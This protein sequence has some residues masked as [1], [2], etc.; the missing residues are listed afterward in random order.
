MKTYLDNL[1]EILLTALAGTVLRV[2]ALYPVLR[3]LL[4]GSC[5]LSL[6]LFAFAGLLLY[7]FGVLPLRSFGYMRLRTFSGGS[8]A[9]GRVGYGQCLSGGLSRLARGIPWCVPLFLL[10]GFW[11]YGFTVMYFQDW[12]MHVLKPLGALV[13]GLADAGTGVLLVLILLSAF[14]AALGWWLDMES[15]FRDLTVRDTRDK[16]RRRRAVRNGA[17]RQRLGSA[18]INILL[19]LPSIVLW[20]VILYRAYLVDIHFEYGLMNAARE[21]AG[22]LRRGASGTVLLRMGLVLFVVHMPLAALR[23]TRSAL[24]ITGLLEGVDHTEA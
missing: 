8:L 17:I 24:L 21:M 10:A 23:K 9:A 13:G 19:T 11:I 7:L 5:T 22:V 3:F 16:R 6:A 20:A 1:G 12:Y 4:E 2:L 14:A 18:G 15:D